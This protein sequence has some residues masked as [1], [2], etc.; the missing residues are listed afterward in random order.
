LSKLKANH[1]ERIAIK[2]GAKS[3][4]GRRHGHVY[5]TYKGKDVATY[6]IRRSSHEVGHDYIPRQ[7]FI[8]MRQAMDLA[9]CP[10]SADQYFD[11]L[12]MHGHL[13]SEESEE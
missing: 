4:E 1:A 8:T 11:I 6:G 10:M 3:E 7:I 12:K 9:R 2:L 5:I 13:P